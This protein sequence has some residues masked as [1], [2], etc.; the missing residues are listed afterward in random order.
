MLKTS[1]LLNWA[2]ETYILHD[3]IKQLKWILQSD[4]GRKINWISSVAKEGKSVWIMYAMFSVFFK[5]EKRR[6]GK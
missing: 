1:F 6:G 5:E 4:R 3:Q 2:T